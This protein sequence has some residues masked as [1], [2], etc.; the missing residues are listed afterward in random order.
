[1]FE[2]LLNLNLYF[3]YYVYYY[4][5]KSLYDGSDFNFIPLIRVYMFLHI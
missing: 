1:M 3:P 4:T 2:V 5:V